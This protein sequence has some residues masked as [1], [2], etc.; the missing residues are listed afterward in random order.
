MK[1]PPRNP[2]VDKQF[3]LWKLATLHTIN[4]PGPKGLKDALKITRKAARTLK[5]EGI[6]R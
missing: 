6:A 2:T 1:P 4:N 5:K 3:Q